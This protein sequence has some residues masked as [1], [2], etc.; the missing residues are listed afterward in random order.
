MD[1]LAVPLSSLWGQAIALLLVVTLVGW[2]QHQPSHMRT[3]AHALGVGKQQ[4]LERLA[5]ASKRAALLS[6]V[7]L[8]TLH[9]ASEWLGGNELDV[10]VL[11]LG[12]VVAVV[13]DLVSEWRGTQGSG[14]FVPAVELHRMY[15]MTFAADKLAA[16]QIPFVVR[17]LN[18]RTFGQFFAPFVPMTILVRPADV[19]RTRSLIGEV[20]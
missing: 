10:D 11:S 8:T 19:A 6:A 7:L 16:E 5:L 3:A 13:A 18:H 1:W 15:V 12:I 20:C 17:G 14:E 4:S 2:L 9:L